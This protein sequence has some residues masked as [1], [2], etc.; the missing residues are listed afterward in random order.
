MRVKVIDVNFATNKNWI[1][2]FVDSNGS[3]Y[4]V[5]DSGFYADEKLNNPVTKMTLD[6]IHVGMWV[7]IES[8]KINGVNIVT[9]I[10]G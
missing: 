8:Q 10:F 9:R 4:Y 6:R 2:R 3:D 7:N 5:K 1:F